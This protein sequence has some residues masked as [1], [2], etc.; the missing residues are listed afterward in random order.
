[1]ATVSIEQVVGKKAVKYKARVRLTKKG[2]KLFEQSKTF[3]TEAQARSW[4]KKL[5]KKLDIEGAP[6][7]KPNKRTILIGDLITKYLEDPETSQDLGRSKAAVLRRLR[8]YDI[9]LIRADELSAND[10]VEHC[11]Q[12]KNE[13]T[14]PKPQTVYQDITYIRS[15][16]N[17]AGDLSPRLVPIS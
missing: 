17:V 16:I 4:A 7:R 10:L 3:T 15:I 9:A 11:R 12:R 6:T 5:V 13:P 1:M 2:K 14:A 8:M